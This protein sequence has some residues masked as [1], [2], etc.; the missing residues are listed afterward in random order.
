M[1][2]REAAWPG[3]THVINFDIPASVEDY[4]HR[5]GRSA[6]GIVS[7]VVS[8]QDLPMVKKIEDSLGEK[9][10]RCS[11]PGIEQWEELEKKATAVRRRL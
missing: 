8:W 10:P 11:V 3:I 1:Q 9:I 6:L 7:T 2:R 4:V 5:A